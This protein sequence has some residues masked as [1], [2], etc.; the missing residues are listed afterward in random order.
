M[1]EPNFKIVCNCIHELLNV[2]EGSAAYYSST[3]VDHVLHAWVLHMKYK[4]VLY[5]TCVF[6]CITYPPSML[7][8]FVM[9]VC[10]YVECT[11]HS[12]PMVSVLYRS[13][14]CNFW[15]KLL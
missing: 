14:K 13:V 2:F 3:S 6:A 1:N 12:L 11:F 8:A 15:R 10:Q 7:I 9:Y 4:Q 5:L